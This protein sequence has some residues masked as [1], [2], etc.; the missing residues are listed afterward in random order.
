MPLR[1]EEKLN[2]VDQYCL[3]QIWRITASEDIVEE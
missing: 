1:H 3:V 2:G